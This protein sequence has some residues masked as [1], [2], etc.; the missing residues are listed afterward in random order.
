MRR[1]AITQII[2]PTKTKLSSQFIQL[3][4]SVKPGFSSEGRVFWERAQKSDGR[5]SFRRDELEER[6]YLPPM[7]GIMLPILTMLQRDLDER[8]E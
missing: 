4:F 8:E 1:N 7:K 5:K 6:Y 2:L 3:P